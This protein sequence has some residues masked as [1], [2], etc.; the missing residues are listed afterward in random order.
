M[1][2]EKTREKLENKR[3]YNRTQ[4]FLWTYLEIWNTFQIKEIELNRTHIS[5]SEVIKWNDDGSE[6]YC[7]GSDNINN[8]KG[9]RRETGN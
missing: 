6:S 1:D 8:E 5:N 2:N 4:Y 3:V 9:N 7:S